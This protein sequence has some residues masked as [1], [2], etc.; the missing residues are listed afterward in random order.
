M[1][2]V[3]AIKIEPKI[4]LRLGKKKRVGILNKGKNNTFINNTFE[5]LDVAIQDEGADTF[6]AGNKVK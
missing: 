2:D 5:D 6:A 3:N 4:N 1:F